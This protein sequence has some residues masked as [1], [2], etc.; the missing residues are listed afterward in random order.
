MKEMINQ[1]RQKL[2]GYLREAQK[3]RD[4]AAQP[5]ACLTLWCRPF[6]ALRVVPRRVVPRRT[7]WALPLFPLSFPGREEG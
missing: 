7:N 5:P 4:G 1:E 3:V 2:V 6:A